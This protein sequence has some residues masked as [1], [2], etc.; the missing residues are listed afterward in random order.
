MSEDQQFI[1]ILVQEINKETVEKI[2]NLFFELVEKNKFLLIT[3][4]FL[5]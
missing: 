1:K 5:P 2:R 3:L 4:G